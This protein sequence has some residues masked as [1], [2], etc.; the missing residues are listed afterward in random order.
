LDLNNI[1]YGNPTIEQKKYLDQ[2]SIVD[3]LFI[4]LKGEIFP[5]NDSE[6]VKDELNEL[7]D[8][9]EMLLEQ[10]NSS[11]LTRFKSY[12]RSLSQAIISAFKQKGID[13]EHLTLDIIEDIKPLLIKLKYFYQRPRPKQIAQYYK[14]AM[15]PFNSF[16]ADT[17][18]YP[19]GHALEAYV[20]LN[21]IAN[22]FPNEFQF[23]KSMA[24]DV[25]ISRIH[26]GLHY[27]TDNDFA[28]QIGKEILKHKAF[29]NKYG[30]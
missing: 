25:A 21:V 5:E 15:F 11:Y 28:K 4:K 27:T 23:C 1:T 29:T 13:V 20:V 30:I 16:S 10:E 9:T 3:D 18:S 7:V 2:V 26:L 19:S 12:D 14:L 8:M 17:P 22:K 24:Q 6:L